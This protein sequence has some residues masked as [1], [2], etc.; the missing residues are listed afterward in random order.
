VPPSPF[1]AVEITREL[2]AHAKQAM[3]HRLPDRKEWADGV[4][5]RLETFLQEYEQ[6]YGQVGAH[7][8]DSSRR[9]TVQ[10]LEDRVAPPPIHPFFNL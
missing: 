7:Q 6:A 3:D 5:Q 8:G 10:A 1:P 2:V 9:Q 4:K